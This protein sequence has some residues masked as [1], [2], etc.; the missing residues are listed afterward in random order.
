MWRRRPHQAA[1]AQ[2]P[3]GW[4]H[5]AGLPSAP[6]AKAPAAPVEVA[7]DYK[8]AQKRSDILLWGSVG[9]A[10]LLIAGVLYGFMAQVIQPKNAK[11]RSLRAQVQQAQSQYQTNEKKKQALPHLQTLYEVMEIKW[12]DVLPEEGEG[13]HS[14]FFREYG[15]TVENL[16]L[17]LANVG[18]Q[19][20]MF[21]LELKATIYQ[22]RG[23][24]TY[25]FPAYW[26]A[27]HMRKVAMRWGATKVR[28]GEGE[29]KLAG[30]MLLNA[31]PY[32]A[33]YVGQYENVMRLIER[34]YYES[35]YFFA[36]VSVKI[37]RA[38]SAATQVVG[39][40]LGAWVKV[41]L[42]GAAFWINPEGTPNTTFAVSQ[43]GAGP[44]GGPAASGGLLGPA[45]FAAGR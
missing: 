45:E 8:E 22:Q 29:E 1:D 39:I 43:P 19:S 27:R 26:S 37:E 6:P 2:L 42:Q 20:G 9:G 34:M 4:L 24:R 32:E 38:G 7:A 25:Q 11:L 18:F 41:T 21:P 23:K 3:R 40:P 16:L 14:W 31:L 5:P 33:T 30:N 12:K 17:E 28:V 10:V 13:R 36:V 44:A 15:E 35:P